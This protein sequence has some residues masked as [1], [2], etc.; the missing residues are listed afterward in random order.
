MKKIYPLIALVNLTLIVGVIV[1]LML[2]KQK[3]VYVDANKLIN[4]YQ[5]MIDARE[6]YKGKVNVWKSN[7][8][9]LASELTQKVKEFEQDKSNMSPREVIVTKELIATKESQ[10]RDFQQAMNTKAQQ[11]DEEMT[12]KILDEING[13]LK[14]YGKRNGYT[15]ILAATT[16]GNI[17]YAEE[18]LDLTEQILEELNRAYAK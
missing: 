5:R 15:I 12:K 14:Q 18:E 7:I 13:Y 6:V 4:G 17:A 2:N 11:E 16:Y 8:D 1:F 10:F 9:T 3:I